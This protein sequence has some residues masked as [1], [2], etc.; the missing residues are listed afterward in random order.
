MLVPPDAQ[1]GGYRAT[2]TVTADGK[3]TP[4]RVSIRVFDVRLPAPSAVQGNL[5]TA[6]H[7]VPQSYVSKVD[8]LYHLGLERGALGREREALLV[9]GREPDLAGRLGLRRAEVAR[10]LH[11][12]AASGGS[13]PPGT[14]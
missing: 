1:P 12:L 7:V 3:P 10:G 2:V 11:V 4:I 13:T 14:W 5:L 8:Q 9:P 6:F